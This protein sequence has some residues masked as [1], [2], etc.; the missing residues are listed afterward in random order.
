MLKARSTQHKVNQDAYATLLGHLVKW[1]AD[2]HKLADISGL[3]L[4]TV[5]DLL[6]AFHRKDVVFICGWNKDSMGRDTTPVFHLK[7]KPTDKDVPRRVM[8]PAERQAAY[9][10]RRALAA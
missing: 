2:C 3:H 8:T 5:Q 9:R 4:V 1:A 7:L 10:Q 6:R